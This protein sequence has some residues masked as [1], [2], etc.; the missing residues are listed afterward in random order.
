MYS[1]LQKIAAQLY[2]QYL[3]Y[4][5]LISV[6]A[7]SRKTIDQR[8]IIKLGQTSRCNFLVSC[9]PLQL[10]RRL[11]ALLNIVKRANLS[12]A[13]AIALFCELF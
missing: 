5:L 13:L 3:L 8:Q 7:S 6:L 2:M 11:L 9:K 12:I 1:A 4:I 10:L